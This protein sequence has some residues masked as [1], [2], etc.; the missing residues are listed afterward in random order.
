MNYKSITHILYRV[1]ATVQPIKGT[2]D[3]TVF[4]PAG[5]EVWTISPTLRA[6]KPQIMLPEMNSEKQDQGPG[7]ISWLLGKGQGMTGEQFD[8]MGLYT[9]SFC[10]VY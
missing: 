7:L 2:C 6:E 4:T 8:N 10:Y 5:L 9:A 1:L 3:F